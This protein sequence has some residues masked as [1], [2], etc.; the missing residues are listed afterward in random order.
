MN[1]MPVSYRPKGWPILLLSVTVFGLLGVGAWL[2][3][4][5]ISS[6]GRQVVTLLSPSPLQAF[7]SLLATCSILAWIAWRTHWIEKLEGLSP[8]ALFLLSLCPVVIPYLTNQLSFAL[9]GVFRP[10]WH[11]WFLQDGATP[12]FEG[13]LLSVVLF[14]SVAAKA[15]ETL[16]AR[17]DM[18]PYCDHDWTNTLKLNLIVAAGCMIWT[19]TVFYLGKHPLAATTGMLTAGLFWIRVSVS[20]TR[21]P[22]LAMFA[23]APVLG[24][25]A[26][27][28]APVIVSVMQKS[29]HVIL[30]GSLVGLAC[31]Y[32][33]RD[34]SERFDW[35]QGMN[36]AFISAI[37]AAFGL[38]VATIGSVLWFLFETLSDIHFAGGAIPYKWEQLLTAAGVLQQDRWGLGF[39]ANQVRMI[40]SSSGWDGIQ[41][42]ARLPHAWDDYMLLTLVAQH[43][44][45]AGVAVTLLLISFLALTYVGIRCQTGRYIFPFAMM[46]WSFMALSSL[47][48]L[49]AN[50]GVLPGIPFLGQPFL[51]YHFFL[52]SL[53]GLLAGLAMKGFNAHALSRANS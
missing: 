17:S 36:W 51:S 16:A 15:T 33:S 53:G 12:Y 22:S 41:V 28:M 45:F 14:M 37:G 39:S 49:Q 35:H 47:I 9:R 3:P 27:M 2:L 7:V 23:L 10:S 1:D 30:T 6:H 31:G 13:S 11:L 43:G 52:V 40:L 24:M 29:L 46:L 19:A 38:G 26:G 20:S 4:A 5:A 32:L 48:N 8:G 44:W 18:I 50:L 42:V 25:L 34:T 21:G